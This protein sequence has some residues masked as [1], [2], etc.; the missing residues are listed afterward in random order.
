[1]TKMGTDAFLDVDNLI[2]SCC[3]A[4]LLP[5]SARQSD[6]KVKTIILPLEDFL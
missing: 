1:M 6:D 5:Y 4:G 3:V 2:D